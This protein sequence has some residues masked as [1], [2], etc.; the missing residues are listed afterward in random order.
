[1]SVVFSFD[2]TF[3]L[4]RSSELVIKYRYHNIHNKLE[5][6]PLAGLYSLV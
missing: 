4:R 6:L 1:V 5:C 2:A 3:K